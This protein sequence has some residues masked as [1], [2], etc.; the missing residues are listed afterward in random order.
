M[1]TRWLF[2]LFLF[3]VGN[4]VAQEPS[5]AHRAVEQALTLPPTERAEALL[6]VAQVWS[7]TAAGERAFDVGLGYLAAMFDRMDSVPVLRDQLVEDDSEFRLHQGDVA[8]LRAGRMLAAFESLYRSRRDEWAGDVRE[9]AE[10]L[11]F[12]LTVATPVR[13][14]AWLRPDQILRAPRLDVAMTATAWPWQRGGTLLERY[15]A[16]S[17]RH[18]LPSGSGASAPALAKGVWALELREVDTRFA[19]RR[20]V[21][22][23]DLEVEVLQGPDGLVVFVHRDG[24]PVS[25]AE[26]AWRGEPSRPTDVRGLVALPSSSRAHELVVRDGRDEVFQGLRWGRSAA[27]VPAAERIHI[28]VDAPLY[29]PG[30]VL[31]GRIAVRGVH[32]GQVV[33]PLGL[34]VRQCVGSASADEALRVRIHLPEA[35][36]QVVPVVLDR[37]GC[38]AFELS[39]PKGAAT[40]SVRIDVLRTAKTVVAD[41]EHA[42]DVVLHREYCTEVA[43][44]ARSP[45]TMDLR[46]SDVVDPDARSTDLVAT[47]RWAHGAPAVGRPVTLQV[48]G[49]TTM[50]RRPAQTKGVTDADGRVVFPV[51]LTERSRGAVG[52]R[53][54][55]KSG[56]CRATWDGPNERLP[57]ALGWSLTDRGRGTIQV[58]GE[59][60][61]RALVALFREAP[62]WA[63]AVILGGDGTAQ[64][65]VPD[66]GGLHGDFD[67][68]ALVGTSFDVLPVHLPRPRGLHAVT[69]TVPKSVAPGAIAKVTIRCEDVLGGKARGTVAL[70]VVDERLFGLR[71]D[72]VTDP[73]TALRPAHNRTHFDWW[74]GPNWADPLDILGELVEE[75][76]VRTRGRGLS[77]PGPAGASVAGAAAVRS[78][79]RAVAH[80]VAVQVVDG[81]V[82]IE[83][84]FPD[85]VTTW[86]LTCWAVG[87]GLEG[88]RTVTRT[89]TELPLAVQVALPRLLRVG[90]QLDL[91]IAVHA[92]QVDALPL[93]EG[94]GDGAGIFGEASGRSRVGSLRVAARTKGVGEIA[95]RASAGD[96]ADAQMRRVPVL[97]DMVAHL[98][99]EGRVLRNG[100]ATFEAE[101]DGELVLFA[102][103]VT[104]RAEAEAFLAEYPYGCVEQTLSRITPYLVRGNLDAGERKRREFG[105]RRLRELLVGPDHGFAWWPGE[106]P[107][108]AMTG[109]VTFGLA[110]ARG[111]TSRLPMPS[112]DGKLTRASVRRLQK[113][114]AG[115]PDGIAAAEWVAGALRASPK[116]RVLRANAAALVRGRE[117]L[118]AGLLARL[119]V[120]LEAAGE[121][122]IAVEA[123]RRVD[124]GELV[125]PPAHPSVRFP[126]EDPLA[127]AADAVRLSRALDSGV[128]GVARLGRLELRLFDA[129]AS[130]RG[131][132]YGLA[133]AVVALAGEERARGRNTT[134]LKVHL[135]DRDPETVVLDETAATKRLRVSA[136]VVRVEG[137]KDS[138]V[139]V[140]YLRTTLGAADAVE[141]WRDGLHVQCDADPCVVGVVSE[142]RMT[143]TADVD[144]QRILLECPLPAGFEVVDPGYGW[145]LRDDRAFVGRSNL[146][147]GKQWKT[148]LKVVPGM[149]GRVLW[150]S[151]T[152][153]AMYAP[154]IRGGAAGRRVRVRG[155]ESAAMVASGPSVLLERA[156]R[157]RVAASESAE[158][159][160]P[161]PEE[162]MVALLSADPLD[163]AAL[164]IAFDAAVA[165]GDVDDVAWYVGQNP[166]A[167]IALTPRLLAQMAEVDADDRDTLWRALPDGVRRSMT[168]ATIRYAMEPSDDD[169]FRWL[170]ASA[171]GRAALADWL[172]DPKFVDYHGD[173]LL[174]LTGPD[175]EIWRDVAVTD[176]ARLWD[177]DVA[178]T[179]LV[180]SASTDSEIA[181]FLDRATEVDRVALAVRALELRGHDGAGLS[182]W[183]ADLLASRRGD[184]DAAWRLRELLPD[185]EGEYAEDADPLMEEIAEVIAWALLP[186]ATPRELAW[187][188]DSF[189]V[190][191]FEARCA[192]L[193]EV[194]RIVLLDELRRVNG[195][196]DRFVL[197]GALSVREQSALWAWA[198]A[199]DGDALERLTGSKA[200]NLA[201]RERIL[202]GGLERGD[203][204][205][206]YLQATGRD[207]ATGDGR[208]G[209]RGLWREI[210]RGGWEQDWSAGE[211]AR[212][213]RIRR[214]LGTSARERADL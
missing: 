8:R 194:E 69:V 141:A 70:A 158:D 31:R 180:A 68:V 83:I 185:E 107:D 139:G 61:A 89:R 4:G 125:I 67:V 165:T 112:P 202:R 106:S 40:G 57:K 176:F 95:L 134:R 192:E 130:G 113:P 96:N 78:D 169:D 157:A 100:V 193:S 138:M 124:R 187:M 129:F 16:G 203:W 77:S 142:I 53:F 160:S 101:S 12:E 188:Q 44:Y 7:D 66:L 189:E 86:R 81:E 55:A 32:R 90:D 166:T 3:L 195:V 30:H 161:T 206:A 116:S 162:R 127:V 213:E 46:G 34:P 73:R 179:G 171:S 119:G 26:V 131:T 97:S 172:E 33:G 118:P 47:L 170:L 2:V 200:E 196:V 1:C 56:K 37:S 132:T 14:I 201:L 149:A 65:S 11:L 135:G 6:R 23:T 123:L 167:A 59:P 75:G 72:S 49:H 91:P 177:V 168:A 108:V 210:V 207:L 147:A 105:L 62:A 102:P 51:A 60:G 22:V 186:Q 99:V 52:L 88:A 74:R 209:N 38:A 45:L 143:V 128:D 174:D 48:W 120:A 5:P 183:A 211:R 163:R 191:G 39:I 212:V 79:F 25:G 154:H 150:P 109:L 64:V 137:P 144:V 71:E 54:V 85:D 117:P 84:P 92:R 140:R 82:E 10:T 148:T 208:S 122:E 87:E 153:H 204:P 175:H 181:A 103:E 42:R 145:D 155:F 214:W 133:R 159:Q 173:D 182:G 63:E 28:A 114:V 110:E 164:A 178:V 152:A 18:E 93:W 43:A 94:R 41:R 9:R 104:A 20:L 126:G 13:G 197:P 36:P 15:G 156:P 76:R 190:P 27:T 136:G 198:R 199:G 29:R 151:V 121:Q 184:S 19:A 115:D 205:E 21:A 58:R 98:T 50:G 80:F 35:K 146:T 111:D 24:A 17:Y